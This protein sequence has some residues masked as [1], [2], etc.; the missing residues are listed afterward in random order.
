[1]KNIIHKILGWVITIALPFWLIMTA[2]RLLI[3]PVYPI[4]EYRMPGFP[5][6]DFGF[7]L[8]DRLKWSKPSIQ[9]LVNSEGIEFLGDLK[10]PDGT[11][12]YNERELTHM[13]DVKTLVQLMIKVWIGL[14]IGLLAISLLLY[15]N[16]GREDL[17]NGFKRGGWVSVGLVVALLISVLIRF[18]DLFNWFHYLF[19]TGDTW[20]FYMSDTLIRLFPLRFW[21]DAFIFVGLFTLI[22]GVVI[23]LTLQRKRK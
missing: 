6:D 20:L 17:R 4:I 13:I 23:S 14:S 1:M 9:F 3:T 21:S 18:N 12:I 22:V 16:K 2:I 7:T 5:A 8:D 11:P 10:F 15:F 19:F